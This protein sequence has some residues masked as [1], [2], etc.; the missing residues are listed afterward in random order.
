MHEKIK[1]A[2]P[3]YPSIRH[4]APLNVFAVFDFVFS[5]GFRLLRG[6]RGAHL[7]GNGRLLDE[8]EGHE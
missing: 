7:R 2:K 4:S 6:D 8:C 3:D 1:L 5:C